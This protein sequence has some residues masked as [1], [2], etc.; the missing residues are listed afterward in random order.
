MALGYSGKDVPSLEDD[1]SEVIA[2]FM[3]VI[4]RDHLSTDKE[5]KVTDFARLCTYFTIDSI[6]KL[7]FGEAMGYLEHNADRYGYIEA[8]QNALPIISV[9]SVL[10]L[11]TT[12]LNIPF[13]KNTFAPSRKDSTGI[14]RLLKCVIPTWFI[15]TPVICYGLTYNPQTCGSDS[16]KGAR[17]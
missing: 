6:S 5:T 15:P 13:I 12:I 16:R 14:G 4:K 8:V 2:T 7:G 10:P 9:V 17:W 3:K 11:A 1:I